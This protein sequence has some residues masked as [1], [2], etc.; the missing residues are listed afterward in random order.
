[1]GINLSAREACPSKQWLKRSF[2]LGCKA[3]V[4][5]K[6]VGANW[7]LDQESNIKSSDY[8]RSKIATFPYVYIGGQGKKWRKTPET[9]EKLKKVKLGNR[10]ENIE[11]QKKY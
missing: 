1:M 3:I 7:Q 2:A 11:K 8:N 4:G 9:G 6:A 5:P 10:V